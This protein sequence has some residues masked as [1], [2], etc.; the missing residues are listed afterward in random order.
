MRQ[1]PFCASPPIPGSDFHFSAGFKLNVRFHQS[2]K[3]STMDVRLTL[4]VYGTHSTNRR[5]LNWGSVQG[6]NFIG[7]E[8]CI[9]R[10]DDKLMDL[11]CG[12][13][14]SVAQIVVN[15]G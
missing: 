11:G 6:F 1:P 13:D 12:N 4:C 7:F 5:P 10:D 9:C 8:N 2:S 3:L 14:H 15:G